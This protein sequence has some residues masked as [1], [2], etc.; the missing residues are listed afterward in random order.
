[1]PSLSPRV[2]VA[3]SSDAERGARADRLARFF[4]VPHLSVCEVIRDHA[5]PSAK[6][7]PVLR[8]VAARLVD[9]PGYVIDA[10]PRTLAEAAAVDGLLASLAVPADLVV[11]LRSDEPPGVVIGYYQARGTLAQFLPG[12]DDEAIV[13]S[14][15]RALLNRK[16][17]A[18]HP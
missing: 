16:A 14:V 18:V 15:K 17:R 5:A 8:V 10:A 3:G 7:A 1:V 11:H 6:D 9:S 12:T 2:L 4:R 13:A